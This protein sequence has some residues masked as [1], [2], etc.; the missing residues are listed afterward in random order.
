MKDFD[1]KICDCGE[2]MVEVGQ[3]LTASMTTD[4]GLLCE[5]M[6]FD[7]G[8]NDDSRILLREG[9]VARLLQAQE[10]MQKFSD[11]GI[12]RS[13]WRFKIWD[14]FRTVKT[15]TILYDNYWDEL[16]AEHPDWSD[17]QLKESVEMFVAFPSRD[18]LRPAPHNTGGAVDLTIIEELTTNSLAGKFREIDFG[19]SFDEFN[20]RSHTMHFADLGASAG[21]D[22]SAAIGQNAQKIHTQRIHANRMFFL[23]IMNDVGFA[24][25]PEEWWHFSY[26]DRL[27]ADTKGKDCAI[28]G[29]VE[30]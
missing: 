23:K 24:N 27:W 26:G 15:Q 13:K 17:S 3:N 9:V 8:Y 18:K 22:E 2:K 29:S 25:L 19:T 1:I 10:A 4:T 16:H 12:D 11:D 20:F 5:P 6:Y 14:G 28:Y 21:M 30:L 7:W